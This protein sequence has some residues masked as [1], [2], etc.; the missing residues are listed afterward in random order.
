MANGERSMLKE[1]KVAR[2]A[3]LL[4][5]VLTISGVVSLIYIPGKL[6]VQDNAAETATRIVRMEALYRFGIVNGILSSILFLLLALAL[7]RLLKEVDRGYGKLMV[8]LVLL[9]VPLAFVDALTQIATL[10]LIQGPRY[11]SVFH[12]D[13]RDAVALLLVHIDQQWTV[14]SELLWGLWLVPLG[15][16]V[17]RSGFLPRVLGIW[18]LINAG[19]YVGLSVFGLSTPQYL[20]AMNKIAAPALLGEP[21]FALWL[22]IVGRRPRNFNGLTEVGAT[23]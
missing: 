13:Q 3:G 4:Y 5:I 21:V 2:F 17:Y 9:Q 1:Q 20:P 10:L 23:R 12:P 19:A 7:Y 14:A 6:I 22:L 15:I 16:L 8:L 18:L 11:L